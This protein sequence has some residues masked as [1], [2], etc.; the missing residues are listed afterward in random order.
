MQL[1]NIKVVEMKNERDNS[2]KIKIIQV[3]EGP[4]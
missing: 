4:I 3:M 2:N 1:L